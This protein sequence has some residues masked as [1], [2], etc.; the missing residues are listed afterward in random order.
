MYDWT[1]ILLMRKVNKAEYTKISRCNYM[2]NYG[3]SGLYGKFILPKFRVNWTE[4]NV[5]EKRF[6]I[7]AS[8]SCVLYN[9]ACNDVELQPTKIRACTVIT[10]DIHKAF[11]RSNNLRT[12]K[13]NRISF[14]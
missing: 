1:S 4:E 12:I 5:R 10:R 6:K 2:A 8:K 3:E 13:P 11:L 9:R 14:F 7:D